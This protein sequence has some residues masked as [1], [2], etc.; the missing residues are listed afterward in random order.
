MVVA[1]V[2]SLLVVV[3]GALACC[4][5]GLPV[6]HAGTI[7]ARYASPS[8]SPTSACDSVAPCDLVTAINDAPAGADVVI[9]PGAYFSSAAPLTTELTNPNP[10]TIHAQDPAQ[11]PV[12]YTAA[13]TGLL[14]TDADISDVVLITS[15]TTTGMQLDGGTADHLAV[16]ASAGALGACGLYGAR[17]TDSVCA[18][19][20]DNAPA[21]G[22]VAGGDGTYRNVVRNVTAVASGAGG[23]GLAAAATDAQVATAASNTIFDGTGGDIRLGVTGDG[24]MYV[25]ATYSAYR[26][27]A[28]SVA[29]G[30]LIDG[31]GN[32]SATPEFVN[33]ATGNFQELPTSPTVDAGGKAPVA[34]VDLANL[35]RTIGNATDIGAYELA[36]PPRIHDFRIL[37]VTRHSA[38]ITMRVDG[39]GLAA[40]ESIVTTSRQQ[41][42][43]TADAP[44]VTAQPT[45]MRLRHLARHRHYAVRVVATSS[46][47][48]AISVA[49]AFTTR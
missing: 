23:Y 9:E 15:G 3:M 12:I 22:I 18:Q 46:G 40:T 48:T 31:R 21:I 30:K 36:V 26:P 29:G 20:G 32:I 16:F 5:D 37:K 14:L 8:G 38:T 10:L 6:A 42:V 34:D 19:T 13:S 1:R 11:V 25:K 49:R 43:A 28:T 17:L 39:A 7:Q 24:S 45:T 47:G 4:L 33:A 41:Q 44:V 35:P 27:E 2:L